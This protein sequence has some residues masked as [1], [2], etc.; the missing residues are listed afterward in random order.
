V[1]T[2]HSAYQDWK[3]WRRMRALVLKQDGWPQRTIAAARGVSE[4]AVSQWPAAARHG[5]VDAL[6]TH[7]APGPLPR[8]TP[9]QK[10]LIPEF[11][12]QGPEAYGFRGQVW[13]CARIAK[14]IEEEFGVRY[15][16]GHVG[17]WLAELHW[18][19]QVPIKRA[20]QRDEEA[21]ARWRD[22]EDLGN[23]SRVAIGEQVEID[24][25]GAKARAGHGP[26]GVVHDRVLEAGL[27]RERLFGGDGRAA[28]Q[29]PG[30]GLIDDRI[31]ID[32]G[33]T[34][35]RLMGRIRG[36]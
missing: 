14:V 17:R 8:L 20:I 13:T 15:D 34:A 28:H 18:T 31:P 9:E 21:I 10:R 6:R 33:T 2:H 22:E 36:G 26:A 3:E 11:L 30:T 12:W 19:P 25:E 35:D 24:R 23:P 32:W 29:D 1:A 4:P 16:Q 7:P 27:A 5:G